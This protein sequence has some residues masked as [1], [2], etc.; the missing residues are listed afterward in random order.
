M[1]INP[2]LLKFLF[3]FFQFGGMA[4]LLLSGPI[5]AN[6]ISLI[7]T[8][9]AGIFIGLW[10]IYSMRIDNLRILPD[11]KKDAIFVH[12]GPYGIIRHPMYL[13]IIVTFLPLIISQLSI[14]RL[15]VFIIIIVDLVFKLNFEERL[16]AKA[17]SDY[18]TY[19]KTTFRLIPYIY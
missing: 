9:L 13:A 14:D 19:K 17:F 6:S 2:G 11:L 10:A 3:V 18:E 1:K 16:L 4:Y 5:F 15:L 12:A 7:I 8:E